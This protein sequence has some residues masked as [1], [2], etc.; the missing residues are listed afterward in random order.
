VM[1]VVCENAVLDFATA[2]LAATW[3]DCVACVEVDFVSQTMASFDVSEK[4]GSQTVSQ[5]GHAAFEVDCLD[6]FLVGK[7]SVSLSGDVFY[8]GDCAKGIWNVTSAF[9]G[10]CGGRWLW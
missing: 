2:S 6:D 8:E 7:R 4:V 1:A 9:L 3:M 5:I 10:C